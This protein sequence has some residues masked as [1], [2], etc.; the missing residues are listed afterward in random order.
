[1]PFEVYQHEKKPTAI[2]RVGFSWLAFAF[3]W[4]WAFWNRLWLPGTLL[5]LTD[6]LIAGGIR[7]LGLSPYLGCL[8]LPIRIAAGLKGSEWKSNALRRRGYTYRG[9]TEAAN[10]ALA[11]LRAD[12]EEFSKG[13]VTARSSQGLA[14]GSFG[15]FQQ[16]GAVALLTWK[17]ALRF[18]L[19]IVIAV[20]LLG[21]V[22]ALPILIK[23]DGTV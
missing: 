4:I 17:A 9:N 15:P 11:L 5:L 1:M 20:L 21:A 13:G 8:Y 14:F 22:V 3:V 23:D 19:F 6:L 18:R 16:L 10:A 12:S 2:V 7:F